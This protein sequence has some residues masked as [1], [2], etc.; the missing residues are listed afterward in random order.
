VAG[1]PLFAGLAE[2]NQARILPIDSE[3]SAIWQVLA[4]GKANEIRRI[5]ITASG[6][7][8]RALPAEKFA[9]ITPELA[10][11]HPT[12]K[13]GPKITIDSSTLANKGLEV[14]EAVSLFQ[15]PVDKV[16]VV[17]HKQSIIHSMVEYVDSAI[18][19]QLSNPD[20]RLPITYALFWPERVESDWG[21]MEFDQWLRLDFEPPDFERF[22]ALKMAFEVAARGGTAPAV[23]NAANE[24]AVD[25][26]L[27][28]EIAYLDMAGSIRRAIEGV[29]IVDD[30][31][32]EDIMEADRAAREIAG[33]LQ[34]K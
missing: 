21:R 16:E 20:M 15:V 23:F 26:F 13:M 33:D 31:T 7:P 28:K 18:I 24:V 34:R 30:P 2:K 14:I 6:G 27:R 8:F 32:L 5:I 3:H 17:I 19:A 22:P 9:E 4:A 12:W 11:N 29:T 1:G 10:L 25:L